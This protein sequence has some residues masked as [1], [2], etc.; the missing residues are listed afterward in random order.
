MT[1][2][3]VISVVDSENGANTYVTKDANGVYHILIPK[4]GGV[5]LNVK[6]EKI[7]ASSGPDYV[8][9]IVLGKV[10]SRDG[11]VLTLFND[12]S[13]TLAYADGTKERGSWKFAGD[14][15]VFTNPDKVE[16]APEVDGDG[17]ATYTFKEGS[18]FAFTAVMLTAL[19]SGA[20]F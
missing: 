18:E 12:K 11:S 16:I 7:E 5:W 13:Y 20:T 9:V 3:K 2:Y 8:P 10:T 14:Q 15:L 4:G 19:R 6:V 17:N 1:S